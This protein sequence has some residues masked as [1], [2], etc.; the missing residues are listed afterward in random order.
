MNSQHNNFSS[1][2]SKQEGGDYSAYTDNIIIYESFDTYGYRRGTDGNTI[3]SGQINP[4]IEMSTDYSKNLGIV[5]KN[6][7]DISANIGT[8]N[9]IKTDISGNQMYDYNTPFTLN[10]PKTLL[11]GLVYDNN[12]LT[13]Q[14]NA[15][16]VLGTITAATL[17]VLAIV[18]GKE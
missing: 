12:L 18:I 11:D 2:F 10:K 9:S 14:E 5:N 8:I 6:Y 13:T 17:I 7:I 16:Y 15:I 1:I 3:V 4:L